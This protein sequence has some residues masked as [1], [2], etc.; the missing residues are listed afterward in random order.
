M[1]L[2]NTQC[3]APAEKYQGTRIS[4]NVQNKDGA[5]LLMSLITTI[6]DIAACISKVISMKM[7]LNIHL[8]THPCMT[9]LINPNI[10]TLQHGLTNV[11]FEYAVH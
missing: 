1:C 11:R 6:S 7:L 10:C 5:K 9:I 8:R 3:V 4:H 2:L